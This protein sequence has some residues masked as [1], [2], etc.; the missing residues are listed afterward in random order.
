VR[1]IVA[2]A[3]QRRAVSVA[4]LA[5]EIRTG[6]TSGSARVGAVLS[7]AAAGVRSSAEADLLKLVRGS[8]LPEPLYNPTLYLGDEFIAIPDAWWPDVGVAVEIDSRRWHLSPTDW[9]RTMARHSRMSALGIIVLHYPPRR[10][11]AEPRIVVAEI[12]ST[13]D[14][15]R[16][17]PLLRLRAVPA[18]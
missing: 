15:A 3:L 2:A 17:R 12:K 11:R 4:D 18:R 7:E 8:D 10:L 16:D 13:L 14:A 5:D 6:P 1:T 9:E